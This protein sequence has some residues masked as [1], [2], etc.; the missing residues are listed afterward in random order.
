M[1]FEPS[2]GEWYHFVATYD[3]SNINYFLN[4]E[5]VGQAPCPKGADE[6]SISL[7]IAHSTQF[8]D[9]WDFIGA[10][11]EVR[12]YNRALSDD[13]VKRNFAAEGLAVA[14]AS[15]KLALSWGEVKV[16]R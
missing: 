9:S 8:G 5:N 1:P 6:T 7:K 13:E 4:G 10:V 16:S 2:I 15:D 12:L 11:D 14:N 3:S